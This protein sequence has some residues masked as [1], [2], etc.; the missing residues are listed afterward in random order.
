MAKQ[1]KKKVEEKRQE[2]SKT[3]EKRKKNKKR[4]R[5]TLSSTGAFRCQVCFLIPEEDEEVIYCST[6]TKSFI[7]QILRTRVT[8]GKINTQ[9][10]EHRYINVSS[11][12]F[13]VS[14]TQE[15]GGC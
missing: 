10:L 4:T 6:C 5:I 3:Q 8:H 7:S 2:K 13:G 12:L 11:K 9:T 15:E 1:K 14:S